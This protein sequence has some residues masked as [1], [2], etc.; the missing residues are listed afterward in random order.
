MTDKDFGRKPKFGTVS[1][2][3]PLTPSQK[4]KQRGPDGVSYQVA[5]KGILLIR[6]NVMFSSSFR[7]KPESRCSGTDRK[8]KAGPRLS[9]G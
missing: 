2:K 6:E 7:R 1:K 4:L 8:K 3:V 5:I 9:P